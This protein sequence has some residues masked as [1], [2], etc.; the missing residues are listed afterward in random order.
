MVADLAS[1]LAVL[2][3]RLPTHYRI[4][5]M[6]GVENDRVFTFE[7]GF[8]LEQGMEKGRHLFRIS[9]SFDLLHASLV[10]DLLT[11]RIRLY[12]QTGAHVEG[13]DL[14]LS[15]VTTLDSV[16]IGVLVVARCLLPNKPFRLTGVPAAYVPVLER[17]GL[18]DL[19][20]A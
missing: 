10:K 12:Q 16:A 18:F 5:S 11:D 7:S 6:A 1:S 4:P 3:G 15:E 13:V 20:H 17:L 9:G 8:R 14:D 19:V 2:D